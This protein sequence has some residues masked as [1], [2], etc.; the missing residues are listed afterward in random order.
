MGERSETS[1]NRQDNSSQRQLEGREQRKRKDSS[2]EDLRRKLDKQKEDSTRR[3]DSKSPS[4]R[5]EAGGKGS[6]SRRGH[7]RPDSLSPKRSTKEPE[8]KK[9]YDSSEDE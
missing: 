9:R 5:I 2:P 8:S 3:K 4:R 1:R 6:E 7:A